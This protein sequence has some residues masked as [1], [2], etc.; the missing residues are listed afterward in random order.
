MSSP[1]RPTNLTSLTPLGKDKIMPMASHKIPVATPG[2]V[3]VGAPPETA[4]PP[5]PV[6]PEP[7]YKKEA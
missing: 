4:A 5:I 1:E 3:T 2:R 6:R 7:T